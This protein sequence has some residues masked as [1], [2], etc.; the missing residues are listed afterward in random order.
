MATFR[1]RTLKSGKTSITAQ[2][3]RRSCPYQE[4]RAFD[5]RKTVEAWAKKR[6]AEID[7]GIAAGRTPQKRGA[8]RVTLG[9][10]IDEYIAESTERF[11]GV[12]RTTLGMSDCGAPHKLCVTFRRYGGGQPPPF[13]PPG[14]F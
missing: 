3:V 14:F 1:E 9:D 13:G 10:A 6:E 8:Q 4:A 12:S 5:R 7:A 2:I 11:G